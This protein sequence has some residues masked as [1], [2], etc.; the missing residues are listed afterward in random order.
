MRTFDCAINL[1]IV[2]PLEPMTKLDRIFKECFCEE[3]KIL[4][5]KIFFA[6]EGSKDIHTFFSLYLHKVFCLIIKLRKTIPFRKSL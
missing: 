5:K 1:L 3:K 4:R 6:G 2:A